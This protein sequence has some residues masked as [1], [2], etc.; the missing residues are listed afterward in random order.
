M[1]ESS[2]EHF[3]RE[4]VKRSVRVGIDELPEAIRQQL[5]QEIQ[6]L[7]T[8]EVIS[9][10]LGDMDWLRQN[11]SRLSGQFPNQWLAIKN[12]TVIAS[13]SN[14]EVLLD[15]LQTQRENPGL[16]LRC[17]LK[18]LPQIEHLPEFV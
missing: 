12:G 4:I 10:F 15:E 3:N 16:V 7:L 11:R 17:Q 6:E 14:H 2:T 13:N 8:P 5:E 1:V 18:K 9:R